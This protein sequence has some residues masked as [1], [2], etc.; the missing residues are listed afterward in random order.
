MCYFLRLFFFSYSANTVVPLNF[1]GCFKVMANTH[2]LD[3]LDK[4]VFHI[5]GRTDQNLTN[6]HSYLRGNTSY[7]LWTNHF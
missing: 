7:S 6:V 5:L 3:T 4:A 2:F 1:G